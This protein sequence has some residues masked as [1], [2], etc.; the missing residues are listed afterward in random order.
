MSHRTVFFCRFHRSILNIEHELFYIIGM[1]FAGLNRSYV[2]E[3][4]Q[5]YMSI[6]IFV[7]TLRDN[8]QGMFEILSVPN[9]N[10]GQDWCDPYGVDH[11]IAVCIYAR[12]RV[13]MS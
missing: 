7:W 11:V 6:L 12:N 8:G 5:I 4:I 10:S 9:H 13:I 3:W 1:Q 2:A